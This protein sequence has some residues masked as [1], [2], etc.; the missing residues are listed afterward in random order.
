MHTQDANFANRPPN[1]AVKVLMYGTAD[2]VFSNGSHWRELRRICTSELLTSKR[3]KSFSSIRQEEIS[4]LLNSFTLVAGKSPVNLS[5]RAYE[6]TTDIII[7]SAFGGKCKM[8]GTFL[9]IL[10]EMPEILSGFHLSDLFPS[11]SWLDGDWRVAEG[12]G[13]EE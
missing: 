2:I 7:H 12:K 3:V 13:G 9:E 11:L 1:S 10:K 4:S 6:L 8:R 5:A